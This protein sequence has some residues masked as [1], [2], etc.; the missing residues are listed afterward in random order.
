MGGRSLK[1]IERGAL[2]VGEH[3]CY[4]RGL[5]REI[6]SAEYDVYGALEYESIKLSRIRSVERVG[7]PW[8]DAGFRFDGCRRCGRRRDRK[9]GQTVSHG[10]ERVC[11]LGLVLVNFSDVPAQLGLKAVA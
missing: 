1:P 9:R 11:Q 7:A 6:L 4:L 5:V 3:E 10:T 8:L 2:E